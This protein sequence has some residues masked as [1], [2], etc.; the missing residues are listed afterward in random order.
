MR[1]LTKS[2]ANSTAA[3]LL[4]ISLSAC[5]S[6]TDLLPPESLYPKA[7]THCADYPTLTERTDKT[8][9]RTSKEKAVIAK[10]G[11]GAWEDC[12]DT[13]DSWAER[14]AKYVK[15]YEAETY[16]WFTRM[17]RTATGADKAD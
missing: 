3:F 4:L 1:S 10:E 11:Y 16:G 7:L 8:Q 15:Q 12:H 14:R 13:V 5:A 2:L 9:P 17:Y 6:S